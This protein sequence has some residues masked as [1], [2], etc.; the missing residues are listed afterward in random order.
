M[1]RFWRGFSSDDYIIVLVFGQ[2]W[3]GRFGIGLSDRRWLA[4][5]EE[6]SSTGEAKKVSGV[7]GT[8]LTTDSRHESS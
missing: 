4:S 6:W 7:I 8:T 3:H 5:L 2:G 1:D